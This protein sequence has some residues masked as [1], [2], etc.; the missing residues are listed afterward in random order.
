[1]LLAARGAN[2]FGVVLLHLMKEVGKG[3]T[4]VLAKNL[5]VASAC[6][7]LVRTGHDPILSESEK[8][9]SSRSAQRSMPI[10]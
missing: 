8:N 1:M 5:D 3:L 10:Q 4:T 2:N 7:L 6:F 9:Q